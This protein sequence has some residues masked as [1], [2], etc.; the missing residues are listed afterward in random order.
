[1]KEKIK[2]GGNKRKIREKR[3]KKKQQKQEKKKFNRNCIYTWAAEEESSFPMGT[4]L[5]EVLYQDSAYLQE[6]PCS[7]AVSRFVLE[8]KTLVSFFF[9]HLQRVCLQG[10]HIMDK[11]VL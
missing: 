5:Q 9:Q 2:K 6:F 1:M 11:W 8:V 10:D 4:L 7:A 3:E